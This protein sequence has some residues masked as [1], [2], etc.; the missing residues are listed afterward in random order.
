MAP[1]TVVSRPNMG[2]SSI[3][4]PPSE[5]TYTFD[6]EDL[7]QT[8]AALPTNKGSGKGFAGQGSGSMGPAGGASKGG[9]YS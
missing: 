5:E 4:N 7:R 9:N 3:L 2:P 1:D 6:A 8:I